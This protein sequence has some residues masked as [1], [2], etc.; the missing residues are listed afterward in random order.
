MKRTMILL[1]AVA[2]FACQ[3][4]TRDTFTITG[5]VEGVESA[6]VYLQDRVSGLMVNVDSVELQNGEFVLEGSMPHPELYYLRID[7]VVNRLAFFLEN[8]DIEIV[9]NPEDPSD[10][11]VS[12]SHSHDLHDELMALIAPYDTEIRELQQQTQEAT[13]QRN[14]QLLAELT[15]KS[16]EKNEAKRT[17]VRDFVKKHSDETVSVY[18]AMRHL[19]YGMEYD[20]LSELMTIFDPQLAGT[21][22]YD[23][24]N[25]RAVDLERVA[26]GRQAVDFTVPDVDGNEVS[27]SDFRGQ[28]VL[29]SFWAS[30]CP[31]CRDENPSL[32]LAYD[33]LKEENF[34]ILGVSLDRTREAWLRGIEEDGLTWPQVSDL[35][36]WQ[37]GPAA[38]YVIR[39]IPQ[40]VLIDP[41]GI[42][43]DKNLKYNDLENL[44]AEML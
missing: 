23:D 40:N 7:G 2:L 10:F 8:S 38:L 18:I 19:V 16:A 44:M 1:L 14:E 30:W 12:G 5:K 31:Y 27:L 17:V 36:G 24:L 21:R 9:I 39:N 20:E 34:E 29:I 13:S 26:I 22:Y 28:Y 33:K 43:I 32:V 42:I 4:Q 3:P 6:M 11:T 15:Q 35:Q 37:S 25:Q 41:E